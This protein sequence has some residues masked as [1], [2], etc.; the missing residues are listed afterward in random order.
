MTLF[1]V[2]EISSLFEFL[3]RQFPSLLKYVFPDATVIVSRFGVD[4]KGLRP[5]LVTLDGI[6]IDVRLLQPSNASCPILVTLDGMVTD[7]RLVQ[8][9]NV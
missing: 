8:P 9:R 7:V 6:F 4:A 5:I 1:L 3:M 2:P